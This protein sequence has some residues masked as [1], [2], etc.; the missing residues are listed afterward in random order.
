GAHGPTIMLEPFPNADQL[1]TDSDADHAVEW[2]K[3]VIVA[4][5]NIRGEA[6][7]KPS[8]TIDLLLD[9]GAAADR[10]RA[11][12]TADLLRRLARVDSIRW[13]APNE[14]PP[15]NA[16]A[17][18]GELKVMVPLAGLIDLDAERA[19]LT[20]DIARKEQDAERVRQKLGNP[21][22][23]DKAP[24]DVVAKERQ[25]LADADAALVTLRAQLAALG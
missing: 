16:L 14:N 2:L 20:K 17:L 19:R 13:L 24:A 5:R 23:A 8:Q 4:V 6:G 18:V 12:A 25:K 10:L 7:I 1:P 9:G 11:D 22:F 3:Q 15:V 21:G